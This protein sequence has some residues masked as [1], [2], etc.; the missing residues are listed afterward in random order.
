MQA[1]S[2]RPL[3]DFKHEDIWLNSD[4]LLKRLAALH[5]RPPV[6]YSSM[7]LH[8]LVDTLAVARESGI[9]KRA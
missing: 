1:I 7:L 5:F 6:R 3:N 4:C 2:H 9:S 8:F